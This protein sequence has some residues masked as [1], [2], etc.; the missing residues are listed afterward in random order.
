MKESLESIY[1]LLGL[2]TGV[3]VLSFII[4]AFL[5]KFAKSLGIRHSVDHTIRWSNEAKPSL[6]GISFYFCFLLGF[7]IYAIVFGQADVFQ[8]KSLL[9]LFFSINV[10]FLLG[11]S[12]DAY[13]TKPLLKLFSQI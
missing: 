11:L 13:D 5:L 7:M 9:G 2:F 1:G 12:D 6:G 8:N 4:N 3:L 10:A